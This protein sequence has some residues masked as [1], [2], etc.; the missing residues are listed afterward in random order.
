VVASLVRARA[1]E[2]LQ[3]V[4]LV[5]QQQVGQHGEEPGEDEP[6]V[7]DDEAAGLGHFRDLRAG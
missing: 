6:G 3:G 7:E 1:A 5:T 4:L 2:I